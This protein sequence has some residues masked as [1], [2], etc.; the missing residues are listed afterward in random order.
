MGGV[1]WLVYLPGVIKG[2]IF[3]VINRLIRLTLI[4][5]HML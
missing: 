5:V 1:L 2:G 4:C 3:L